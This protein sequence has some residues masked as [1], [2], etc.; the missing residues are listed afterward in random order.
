MGLQLVVTRAIAGHVTIFILVQGRNKTCNVKDAVQKCQIK[1]K[2]RKNVTSNDL[3]YHHK[4]WCEKSVMAKKT[5][6]KIY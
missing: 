1:Q 3:N 4:I 6:Q 5:F 2:N